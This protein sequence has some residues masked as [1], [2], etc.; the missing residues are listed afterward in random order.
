MIGLILTLALLGLIAWAI[1]TYI[2][3]PQPIKTLIVIVIVVFCILIVVN[4]FG[5]LN[6]DVGIPR[7]RR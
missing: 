2:P 1:V 4:A 7:L 3:M 6:Y 5:L